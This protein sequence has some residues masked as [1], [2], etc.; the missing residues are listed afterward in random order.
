M[1]ADPT[2]SLRRESRDTIQL[3][4]AVSTITQDYLLEFSSEYFIPENLHPELPGPKDHIVDFPEGKIGVYINFFEFANF[5]I[6][7]SQFLFD[8]L[9]YYQIHLSQLSVIGAAKVS[10]FEINCCV[11]NIIPIVSLFRVFYV[12]SY[13]SGWMSFSK[14]PGK[15]TPQC[16][17]KPLDSLKNWNNRFFWV[18]EKVFPTVVAWRTTATKDD[19]P[20][21]NIYT[22]VDVAT[23]DTH[24]TPFQ[25]QSE[26]LLC[27]VGLS[28]NFFLH[29]DEYPTFLNDNDQAPNPTKIKTGTRQR[30]AH[31]VPLMTATASRVIQMV[32]AAELST[33]SGA[34]KATI[35]P[36]LVQEMISMGPTIRKRRRQRDA[37][38][39]RPKAPTK[40]LRKDHDVTRAE[41]SA[42]GGKSLARMSADT[43]FA[44][45]AQK[46]KEPPVVTQTVNDPNPLS[47]AKPLSQQ[48][49]TQ[50]S[51]EKVIA[52][53]QDSERS[54]PSPPTTGSP[55][56]IYQPG[57]VAMG[58]QLRLRFEQ[59]AKLLK[60]SVA[61]VARRD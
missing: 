45:H 25:K 19:K 56:S 5:R 23:L 34:T 46:T 44:L 51:K 9:R 54:T 27:L 57:Q 50:S 40:V 59:E 58:S 8:I 31:E 37:G 61:Q 12:P 13:N 10:H 42:R 16:Y 48:D 36:N 18:D 55:G 33:S 35:E 14:R 2:I 1:G 30:A 17:T 60:K 22:V 29:D 53:D 20:Q 24:R 41:H 26:E 4:D 3:E 6:Y 52:G 39:E 49:V 32:D 28:R 11:L 21:A 47:Y 15:N 7:I 38:E 43:G